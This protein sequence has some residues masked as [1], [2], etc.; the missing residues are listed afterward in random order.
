MLLTSAVTLCLATPAAAQHSRH[1][2]QINLVSDIP[3][4]AAKTDPNL[5]NP[6]GLA[7]SSTSPWWVADNG[8]GVS[9]LYNGAGDAV[10]LVV[11]IPPPSGGSS[12]AAPT[13]AVFN[14]STDFEVTSGN[15]ARFMISAWNPAV[16]L[17]NAILKVDNSSS[18]AIYKG[19]TL[20][21]NGNAHYLYVAN[22]HSGHVEVF[23]THFNLFPLPAG[24]F[25]D[26]TVPAGFAPFNVQNIS[27]NIF[28]AFAMQDA[29][30][31]DEVAGPGLG[32]VD[33]FDASGKLLIR[34]RPG[35]W[36]NAPWG[37][38]LAP[39]GFG[40]FSG[41]LLVGNF[42]SGRIAAFDPQKGHFR[43]LLRGRHGHPITIEGLWA[44]S[45]GNG[46]A[47]G[48]ANTLFFTAGIDDEQ[49]GL[50]GTLAPIPHEKDEGDDGNED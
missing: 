20:A 27:G 36:M 19:A 23:D 2:R 26:A 34:L 50:F 31:E 28:V 3:N 15:P 33:A 4:L 22:F 1:Y 45:F 24:A 46:A 8:T 9:T 40:K 6:W 44:L 17:H 16:D 39:E 11:T 30:K 29:N 47:A 35:R 37:V 13:G 42:G 38:A 43:G 48:P 12:P 21:A 41:H 18:S 32:F 49:H 10:P 7:R 5:V 14:D 25:T